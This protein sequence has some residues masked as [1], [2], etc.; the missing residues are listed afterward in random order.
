MRYIGV[1]SG[2]VAVLAVVAVSVVRPT[3]GGE[4]VSDGHT[5]ITCSLAASIGD[6]GY[7]GAAQREVRAD[8]RVPGQN[9]LDVGEGEA[10]YRED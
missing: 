8:V 7:V 6:N 3:N 4:S 2:F 5:L 1:L 10:R 9:R